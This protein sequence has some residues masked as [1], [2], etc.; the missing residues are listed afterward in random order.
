MADD[1]DRKAFSEM[2]YATTDKTAVNLM[3]DKAE[4][5]KEDVHNMLMVAGMTPAIG[6]V[7]DAADALLY[8]LEGEFGSAALSATAMIPFVGQFVSAKKA[9]RVA[10]KSGEEMVTLY[11]GIE[12]VDDLNV[13]VRKGKVVGNWDKT[14]DASKAVGGDIAERQGR[15]VIDSVLG[16]MG[17]IVSS[18]PKNIDTR[19]TLFTSWKKSVG[20]KYKGKSGIILEF[21]V[22]KSWVNKHGRDAFGSSLSREGRGW[23]TSTFKKS[24]N[25]SYPSLIF[26]EG[27]PTDFITKV[28]K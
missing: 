23:G 7:A 19:N 2:Q 28:H 21:E 6:N 26:T 5:T 4:V 12:G 10:K 17:S 22:P 1:T 25:I 9:L 15:K 27:L 24:A 20:K 14:F 8:T 16:P 13:M 3:G 11:R 18:V